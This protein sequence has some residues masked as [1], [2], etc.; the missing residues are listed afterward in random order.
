[1]HFKTLLAIMST[2][3]AAR[4]INEASGIEKKNSAQTGCQWFGDAP[5][6]AGTCP[7]GWQL[8]YRDAC[9]PGIELF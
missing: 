9:G 1:M 2:M 7:G 4:A 6:C 3:V 8:S 5:L